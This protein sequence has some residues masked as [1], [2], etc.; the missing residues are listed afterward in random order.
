MINNIN[1]DYTFALSITILKAN[2]IIINEIRIMK[3][4]LI[5]MFGEFVRGFLDLLVSDGMIEKGT[6]KGTPGAQLR[7]QLRAQLD[8]PLTI[9]NYDRY[10]F[11]KEEKG[12]PKGTPKGT[13]NN[14]D[15]KIN[16]NNITPY[17]PPKGED[18]EI[19]FNLFW[20]LYDK[21]VGSKEKLQKKWE[22]LPL[23][24]RLAIFAYLPKYKEAQ[25]NKKYWKKKVKNRVHPFSKTDTPDLKNGCTR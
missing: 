15:N 12:T 8:P 22:K 17:N 5:R 18:G 6:A 11:E 7:A 23:E 13:Y 14:K 21:Q 19:S 3:T 2:I 1:N 25:P 10:N 16:N 9:C 4:L 20:D 24:E